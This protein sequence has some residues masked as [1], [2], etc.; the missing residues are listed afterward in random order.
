MSNGNNT[1]S[2]K[3]R[4]ISDMDSK[5]DSSDDEGFGTIRF[6][7]LGGNIDSVNL[8]HF[9]S[10]TI[11]E[12]R[13]EILPKTAYPAI[14]MVFNGR[15][16]ANNAATLSHY[17][18]K[19]DDVI[20]VACDQGSG[21]PIGRS[22]VSPSYSAKSPTSDSFS[23]IGSRPPTS[24]NAPDP[25]GSKNAASMFQNPILRAIFRSP[26][27]LKMILQSDPRFAKL[28]EENPEVMQV[29]NDPNYLTQTM[30]IMENPELMK[31]MMRNHDRALSN[32]EAIPGS[33]NILASTY[34]KM[35]PDQGETNPSTEEANKRLAEKYG[36]KQRE[37]VREINNEPLPNPWAPPPP[38]NPT[39]VNSGFN[40]QFRQRFGSTLS[41]SERSRS[42][43]SWVDNPLNNF[44]MPFQN[45]TNS[46]SIASSSSNLL[47][48]FDFSGADTPQD[49]GSLPNLLGGLNL[50]NT[51]NRN[52]DSNLNQFGDFL[53][54]RESV[55]AEHGSTVASNASNADTTSFKDGSTN[56]H[57][58]STSSNSSQNN[59]GN[60]SQIPQSS[61]S[62]SFDHLSGFGSLPMFNPLNFLNNMNNTQIQP[63][64]SYTELPQQH[65]QQLQEN[66]E[67]N[68]SEQDAYS[69]FSSQLALM[70]DMGFGEKE[71]NYRALLAS[72]GNVESAIEYIL[73]N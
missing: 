3:A 39:N 47:K 32:I 62:S 8:P 11:A 40:S 55:I 23:M 70:E 15:V 20:D 45:N 56:V 2:T 66:I 10:A 12:L 29:F 53:G 65:Q 36:V 61:S 24:S 60:L 67:V 28:V 73:N 72:G 19:D 69:K 42:S 35:M 58:N 33:M 34:K 9:E 26:N 48:P 5:D 46:S 51:D 13:D 1:I 4:I 68:T 22:P 43:S 37:N 27:L 16:L 64:P 63:V 14:R 21:S 57:D 31:E 54:D 38:S 30:E 41:S 6:R 52:P 50:F 18:L 7:T 25:F 17:H 49:I 71:K 44:M 59:F